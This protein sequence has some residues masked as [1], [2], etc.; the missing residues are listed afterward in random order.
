M[1]LILN[2]DHTIKK[3]SVF[4]KK[5]TKNMKYLLVDISTIRKGP[6][7][8]LVENVNL[9]FKD[10]PIDIAMDV[11][12]AD[13]DVPCDDSTMISTS[14]ST[15][16]IEKFYNI[17]PLIKQMFAFNSYREKNSNI[18]NQLFIET[19]QF[20]YGKEYVYINEYDSDKY[21]YKIFHKLKMKTDVDRIL[22]DGDVLI[23]TN[24]KWEIK[25]TMEMEFPFGPFDKIGIPIPST[26]SL[27]LMSFEDYVYFS[28]IHS[29]NIE[30]SYP[31]SDSDDAGYHLL[32]AS[33][34]EE[35]LEMCIF[36]PQ[37]ILMEQKIYGNAM[38]LTLIVETSYGTRSLV[39]DDKE[40]FSDKNMC[41]FKLI[42]KLLKL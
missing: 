42:K 19:I 36:I 20:Q 3:A 25:N 15:D 40:T 23:I 35:I 22:S 29:I 12:Y 24:K 6:L 37:M 33:T 4:T 38:K 26:E 2:Q 34:L 1:N 17:F 14:F 39:I 18:D 11:S 27:Y 5:N 8:T 32:N 30:V 41:I 21:I 28:H 10:L 7:F 9:G 16:T 31:G 13:M